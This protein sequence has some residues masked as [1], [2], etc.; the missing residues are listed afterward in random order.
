[1][2]RTDMPLINHLRKTVGV[3]AAVVYNRLPLFLMPEE[4][5]DLMLHE[6]DILAAGPNILPHPFDEFLIDFPY[7]TSAANQVIGFRNLDRGRLWVRVRSFDA[8]RPDDPATTIQ[9][10]QLDFL[11]TCSQGLFLEGW[12]QRTQYGGLP[13]YPDYSVMGTNRGAFDNY[14]T[15]LHCLSK[16]GMRET[17]FV[18]ERFWMVQHP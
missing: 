6:A 8:I 16:P 3:E 2:T 13:P 7:G 17:P 9:Q 15:Y 10:H 12:E 4:S 14:I 11:K 1:M 18:W 5:S